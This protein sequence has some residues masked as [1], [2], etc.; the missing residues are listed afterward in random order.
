[1][2]RRGRKHL[3][4]VNEESAEQEQHLEREAV[5]EN[6]GIQ[7]GSMVGK[8]VGLVV[9]LVVVAAIIGLIILTTR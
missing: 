5:L 1:M 3:Q 8:I 9:G 2:K 4:K 7:P 6:L